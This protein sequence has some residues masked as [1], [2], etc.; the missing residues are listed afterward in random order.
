[1]VRKG[2][3]NGGGGSIGGAQS[4]DPLFYSLPAESCLFIEQILKGMVHPPVWTLS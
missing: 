4:V 3:K 1:M 2:R